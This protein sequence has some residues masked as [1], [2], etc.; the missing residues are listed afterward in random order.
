MGIKPR[1]KYTVSNQSTTLITLQ[2]PTIQFTSLLINSQYGRAQSDHNDL[3]EMVWGTAAMNFRGTSLKVHWLKKPARILCSQIFLSPAPAPANTSHTGK[4]Y[5]YPLSPPMN[6]SLLNASGFDGTASDISS[7]D[8]ASMNSYTGTDSAIY[9]PL[10]GSRT[11]FQLDPVQQQDVRWSSGTDS[12][13]NSD[14][15]WN[16]SVSSYPYQSTRSSFGS[17]YST[18]QDQRKT[19]IDSSIQGDVLYNSGFMA[20]VGHGQAMITAGQQHH[21]QRRVMR[22]LS[23][24]FENHNTLSD[25]IGVIGDSTTNVVG[26]SDACVSAVSKWRRNSEQIH[27]D[28]L[29]NPEMARRKASGETISIPFYSHGRLTGHGANNG[30]GHSNGRRSKLGIAVCVTL[31]ESYER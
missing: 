28:R 5:H 21:M 22:N 4:P 25:Y 3:G 8:T 29:S 1:K 30:G 17:V 18:D 20:M 26:G 11:S 27:N 23:T 19:S 9:S 12:G 15:P 31:D 6:M 24:S 14:S 7:L 2:R 16:T 10:D 13:V